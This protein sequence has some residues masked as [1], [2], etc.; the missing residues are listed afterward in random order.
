MIYFFLAVA[1]LIIG[2]LV[3]SKVVEANFG[4]DTCRATPACRLED[5]VDF[6]KMNKK[7]AYLIQ[8]LN[9]AGLGPIFGPILGALYGPTALVWIVIGSIFAGGVH[10][11]FS[12]MMSV[13]YDGKS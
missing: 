3:Y 12:G 13:R 7:Q 8:L 9:I 5:G 6:V 10:D 2:Y 4:A 1:A 11:Y